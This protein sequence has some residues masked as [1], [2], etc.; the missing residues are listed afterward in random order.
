MAIARYGE[1][2]KISQNVSPIYYCYL[3][4]IRGMWLGRP[5]GSPVLYTSVG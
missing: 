3:L 4:L 2:G 5:N 1:D